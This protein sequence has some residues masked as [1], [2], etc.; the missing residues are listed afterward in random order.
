ML[1]RAWVGGPER[2]RTADLLIANK[3][4]FAFPEFPMITSDYQPVGTPSYLGRVVYIKISVAS[5]KFPPGGHLAVTEQDTPSWKIL[6]TA[7]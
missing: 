3:R 7:F 6:G 4:A 5:W 2:D 1:I